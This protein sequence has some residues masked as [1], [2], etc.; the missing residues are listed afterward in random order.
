VFR[1]KS[2]VFSMVGIVGVL[3]LVGVFFFGSQVSSAWGLTK[4]NSAKVQIL[5]SN[6]EIFTDVNCTIP[7]TATTNLDFGTIREGSTSTNTVKLF[8]KN[9]GTDNITTTGS[10]S[11]LDSHLTLVDSKFG[12]I[13]TNTPLY[14]TEVS[15]INANGFKI[16]DVPLTPLGAGLVQVLNLNITATAGAPIGSTINFNLQINSTSGY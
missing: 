11:G 5:G 6:A 8:I 16:I 13:G 12:V 7:L 9:S 4:V 10:V 15:H 1:K 14:Q 3:I 2:V